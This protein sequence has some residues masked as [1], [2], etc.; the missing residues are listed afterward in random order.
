MKLTINT[1]ISILHNLAKV[2]SDNKDYL[3]K[4]DSVAGDGDLGLSMT[5]G[6]CAVSDMCAQNEFSDIG[7]LLYH[8]GK[9]FS[10]HAPSSLGTL[11]A[12]GFMAAGK[13]FK[14]ITEMD[15]NRFT[16]F[17]EVFEQAIIQRGKAK[18]GEKT[19]LDGF[20]PALE[21][22]QNVS[23]DDNETNALQKAAEASKHGAQNTIGMLARHGRIAI[24]GEA[25]REI[26]D[27]GAVMASLF[28]D[29]FI[30]TILTKEP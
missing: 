21:V 26:L 27:P 24:R 7:T 22:L 3:I 20:H 25:S 19:F 18:V 1:V 4:L 17:L 2:I 13:E 28:I 9:T 23:Y 14:G 30:S 8:A 12:S 15:I 5:D 29:T 6:F 10:T 16:H 11:L